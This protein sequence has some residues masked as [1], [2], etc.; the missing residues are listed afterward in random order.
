MFPAFKASDGLENANAG[1]TLVYFL[2]SHWF[3]GMDASTVVYL[4]SAAKSPITIS[5]TNATVASVIGY[6]F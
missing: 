2:T 5:N 4:G 1:V 3:V 6:H